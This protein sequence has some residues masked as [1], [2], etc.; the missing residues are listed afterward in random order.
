M[1][2]YINYILNK[3]KKTP[4]EILT[5]MINCSY[6]QKHEIKNINYKSIFI[7]DEFFVFIKR[8]F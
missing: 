3:T 7:F 2:Y 8:F 4:D 6:S 5:F 1:I